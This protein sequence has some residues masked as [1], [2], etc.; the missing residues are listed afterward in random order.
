MIEPQGYIDTFVSQ[1]RSVLVL[2]KLITKLGHEL[3][4][5]EFFTTT[6]ISSSFTCSVDLLNSFFDLFLGELVYPLHEF[7]LLLMNALLLGLRALDCPKVWWKVIPKVAS[8]ENRLLVQPVPLLLIIVRVV[9]LCGNQTFL[10][11]YVCVE[12]HFSPFL[13]QLYS[14][15]KLN[16][17]FNQTEQVLVHLSFEADLW[18]ECLL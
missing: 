13:F 4:I 3:L 5:V 15:I 14:F 16:L 1:T 10:F 12:D 18:N 2:Q 17:L 7:S 9:E 8:M 6:I 11:F